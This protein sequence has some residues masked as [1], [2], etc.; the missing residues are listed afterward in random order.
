MKFL[1]QKINNEIRHDFAFTLLESI[2]FHNWLSPGLEH[3][4]VQYMNTE[5]DDNDV[6]QPFKFLKYHNDSIPI[7]SVEFVTQFLETFHGITPKPI[8]VPT[9]LYQFAQRDIFVGTN[10][11]LEGLKG[12]WFIKSHEKIKG[13]ARDII[14]PDSL[15]VPDGT[16]QISRHITIDS[17]WRT[18]V[19]KGKMVGLQHYVGEFTLFPDVNQIKRMIDAY[20]D[21]PVAYTLDIGI[22]DEGTFVIEVH[23]FFS[24]GLYG[25]SDHSKLPSMFTRW[26]KEYINK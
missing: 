6:V 20:K 13:F 8:N 14:N 15:S 17:E 26:F 23:D 24:C 7:G 21:A 12:W 11:N 1:I 22:N 16:Y 25:F 9:Q 2:R 5:M 3:M 4:G 19:Y 18:F 10:S